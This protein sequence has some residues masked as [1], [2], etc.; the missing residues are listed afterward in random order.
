MWTTAARRAGV[1]GF[2][3][4]DV[5]HFSA[6]VHIDQGASVKAVQEFLGHASAAVTLNTSAHRTNPAI[7]ATKVR[8][9]TE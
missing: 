8:D 3:P 2:T 6:S 9:T 1:V 7:S 4:H 5:R